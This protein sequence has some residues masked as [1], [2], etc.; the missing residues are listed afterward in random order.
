MSQVA[1]NKGEYFTS[2]YKVESY[3]VYM[4]GI[5]ILCYTNSRWFHLT[6]WNQPT[7]VSRDDVIQEC[8]ALNILY[9]TPS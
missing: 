2:I 9:I 7:A 6:L 5:S 4:N 8:Y 1:K 3:L